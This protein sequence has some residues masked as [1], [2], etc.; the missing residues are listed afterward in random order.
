MSGDSLPTVGELAEVPTPAG[1]TQVGPIFNFAGHMTVDGDSGEVKHRATSDQV[2]V[3]FQRPDGS[4]RIQAQSNSFSFA[5]VK[6]YRDWHAFISEAEP[7]WVEYRDLVKPTRIERIGLRYVNIIPMPRPDIEIG[8]YLR[9]TVHVSPYLPQM[10]ESV[11]MQVDI[12]FPGTDLTATITSGVVDA[13]EPGR[14]GLLLDIDVKSDTPLTVDEEDFHL[15]VLDRL[16]GLRRCKNHVFEA[17]ITDATRGL[18]A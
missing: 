15:Q 13:D 5:W 18:I 14:I 4:R 10:I 12:P 2:G 1:Y 16:D 8:D 6:E 17:C 9:T 7:S 11:F 3:Q